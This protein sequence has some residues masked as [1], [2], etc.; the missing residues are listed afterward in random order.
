MVRAVRCIAGFAF[1]ASLIAAC[2]APQPIG[3]CPR[4]E[5]IDAPPAPRADGLLPE[6]AIP[7]LYR[8]TFTIDPKLARFSGHV[9]IDAT[10]PKS[11]RHIVLHGRSLHI[12]EAR[13][14]MLGEKEWH[15]ATTEARLSN[16]GTVNEEL[17]VSFEKPMVGKAQLDFSFDAPFDDELL[18]IYKT[19]D[20]GRDYVLSQFEAVE[21]RRAFPCFDEPRYKTPF[22]LTVEVPTGVT[23][24]S[25]TREI[26]RAVEGPQTRFRFAQTPPLPTYL[27][28]LAIGDFEIV[29][30]PPAH[31]GNLPMRVVAAKGKAHLGQS[32]FETARVAVDGL[33]NYFGAPHPYP[34][35]DL[36]AFPDFAAGAM[37]N[38]GLITFREQV[39][40]LDPKNR[41]AHAER[42]H[43]LTVTHELAHQWFGN[44]VTTAWWDDLWLNEGFAMWMEARILET[45]RPDLHTAKEASFNSLHVMDLDSLP[46]VRA[47]R[48]PVRSSAEAAEA[49]D[50][51]TYSK[52][53]AILRML[54][55]WIGAEAFRDAIRVYTRKFAGRSVHAS[56]FFGV[57]EEQTKKPVSRVASEFV[58]KPGVP[59]LSFA[60]ACDS[61][62]AHLNVEER[63]YRPKGFAAVPE[64]SWTIP[65]CVRHSNAANQECFIVDRQTRTLPLGGNTCPT[66]V[67]PNARGA[68]YFRFDLPE[69]EWA[70]LFAHL[71][72]LDV[73]EK[74]AALASLMASVNTGKVPPTV[75][76]E[77]LPQF[78]R[79]MDSDL[80][81]QIVRVLEGLSRTFVNDKNRAPFRA[82]ASARLAPKKRTLGWGENAKGESSEAALHRRTLLYAMA[83]IAHDPETRKE[84]ELIAQRWFRDPHA[85][86]ADTAE[87][88]L[89]IASRDAKKERVDQL[90][91]ALDRASSPAERTSLLRATTGFDDDA[92][93]AEGLSLLLTDSVK[94]QDLRYTVDNSGHRL[95][96]AEATR[97]W[98]FSHWNE[99]TKKFVGSLGR[100]FVGLT[101]EACTEAA[102]TESTHFF[103]DRVKSIDGA[104]RAYKEGVDQ[105]TMCIALRA[106][107]PLAPGDFTR[108]K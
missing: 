60:L 98:V 59:L 45:L 20:H 17:V 28:A 8:V 95:A 57:L 34:K 89:D 104:E 11:T 107:P 32:A 21:A 64:A 15:P 67:H 5:P 86:S 46:S 22:E 84:A 3:S 90:R 56:D 26:E 66:W 10:I 94:M 93:L 70:H 25:N 50:S 106:L 71:G 76:V 2:G 108:R 100:Y 63:T 88:A 69:T 101:K 80:T 19:N 14:Q 13:G 53:G 96:T 68:G 51:I 82:W 47:V 77:L 40:L 39:L 43:W 78:D 97:R 74:G 12:R 73:P 29:D 7:N 18:G 24:L 105:A 65:V 87:I 37:E 41:S 75:L 79:E 38:P 102:L 83:D 31:N 55:N 58:D 9:S 91:A 52:G 85:I 44:S 6:S 23:V 72:E 35:L 99:L 33:A 1:V 27:L 42:M 81:E 36:V 16:G 61:K 92:T 49:F 4:Q 62:G 48:Q 103:S 54:E 30:G